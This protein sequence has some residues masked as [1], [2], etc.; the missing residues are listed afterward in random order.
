MT[1]HFK[2]INEKKKSKY[3]LSLLAKLLFNMKCLS[4][5][6]E[7]CNVQR[8]TKNG[9]QATNF[10]IFH[11]SSIFCLNISYSTF[12]ICH[13]CLGWKFERQT[14]LYIARE[15]EDW[16]SKFYYLVI[17]FFTQKT[18]GVQPFAPIILI[19]TK[20]VIWF[21]IIGIFYVHCLIPLELYIKKQTISFFFK[22]TK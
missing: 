13:P 12:V 20:V 6:L 2:L 14:T 9:L 10:S 8:L 19:S 3:R 22:L 16:Y 5:R 7:K 15:G 18:L 11:F 1:K 17:L 4:V 21:I